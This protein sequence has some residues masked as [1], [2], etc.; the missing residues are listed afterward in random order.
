MTDFMSSGTGNS[1][2]LKSVSTFLQDYPT[3]EDFA[4]A[5]ISGTLPVDFNG[6]NAAGIRQAGTPL[7][8]ATLLSSDTAALFGLSGDD[9]TVNNVL[10]FIGSGGISSGGGNGTIYAVCD[11]AA[12]EAIKNI[13]ISQTIVPETEG[14]QFAVYFPNGNTYL[15]SNLKLSVTYGGS[16]AHYDYTIQAEFAGPANWF[17]DYL[18]RGGSIVNFTIVSRTNTGQYDAA[19]LVSSYIGSPRTETGNYSGTGLYGSRSN[20]TEISAKCCPKLGIIAKTSGGDICIIANGLP[21]VSVNGTWHSC[22]G[23]YDSSNNKIYL[24][25]DSSAEAQMNASGTSYTYAFIY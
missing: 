8:S 13:T 17:Y 19:P 2:Y 1:R 5:L 9:A 7:N 18:W 10:N 11:T 20:A 24:Y 12:N 4:R 16:E 22:S 6:I 15:G 14:L 25:S 3:Y 21:W 23:G